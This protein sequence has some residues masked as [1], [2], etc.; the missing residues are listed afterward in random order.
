MLN[1]KMDGGKTASEGADPAEARCTGCVAV[2]GVVE[3]EEARSPRLAADLPV[4]ERHLQRD[5]DC[6]GTVIRIKNARERST[7]CPDKLLR[8]LNGGRIA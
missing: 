6:G 4:L 2:V 7:G 3:S 8:Q 1:R 5:L